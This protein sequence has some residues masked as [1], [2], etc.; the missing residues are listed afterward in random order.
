LEVYG[1]FEES[2]ALVCFVLIY[3]ICPVSVEVGEVARR[4]YECGLFRE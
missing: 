2:S 1:F 3:H 4:G